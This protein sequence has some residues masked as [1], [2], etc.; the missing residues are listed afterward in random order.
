MKTSF[1]AQFGLALTLLLMNTT[2]FADTY[3]KNVRHTDPFTVMGQSQPA[4]TETVEIWLGDKAT[5]TDNQ[6]GTS[7]LVMFAE[8][9]IY[10]IKHGD[11]SYTEMPLSIDKIVDQA[12][13]AAG[14]DPKANNKTN[15]AA[16]RNMMKE[17]MKFKV[18]LEDT[19]VKQKIGD[20]QAHKYIMTTQTGM[21]TNTSEIW[22]TEDLHADMTG[23]WQAAN[24]ML[25]GQSDFADMMDEMKKIRGVVVKTVNRTEAMGVEMS[26]TENLVEFATKSAPPATFAVPAGYSKKEMFGE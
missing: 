21:G 3:M 23:Y 20:W 22:A 13:A 16:M 15:S 25:A 5:R 2:A 24:A 18:S 1:F 26:S 17:M 11:H 19:G 10:I 6:D 14:D 7:T 9:K 12:E 4:K 8:K